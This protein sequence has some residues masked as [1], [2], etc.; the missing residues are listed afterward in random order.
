MLRTLT[1]WWDAR[2]LARAHA[3]IDRRLWSVALGRLPLL[4]G[5]PPPETARLVDL[6]ALF[7]ADKT[8]EPTQGATL[9]PVMR[10]E[11]ALQACLPVLEL[12]LDWYRGWHA[13]VLYPDAFVPAREVIDPDGLVWVDD[14]PKSGEAWQHG[15]VIL[16]L[17]DAVAGR[18]RDGFNVVI[19][20]MVHKL[21]MQ[22]GAPNG[23]PPLHRDMSNA[24]WAADLGAAYADLC[25]RADADPDGGD[26][27]PIDPY[28][29]ESPAEFFAVVSETFFELP[30]LLRDEY[31]AVYDQLR[32]FYRQDPATRLRRQATGNW[33]GSQR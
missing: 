30:H 2:R 18:A 9:D 22:N 24:R 19:H 29:T 6:A 4:A 10:L 5:L 1:R 31:P 21:D 13:L 15:P 14:E 25:R 12:G 33:I 8:L 26:G 17:S 20:E 7:L 23:H 32:G 11:L 27:L 28:A 16:S 3:G